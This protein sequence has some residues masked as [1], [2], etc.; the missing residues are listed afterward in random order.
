MGGINVVG[1]EGSV[2]HGAL[3]KSSG[4]VARSRLVRM[5]AQDF[6]LQSWLIDAAYF[7][8]RPFSDL[9]TVPFKVP[10]ATYLDAATVIADH[11]V[12]QAIRKNGAASWICLLKSSV[13]KSDETHY[14]IGL[15]DFNL[16][17]G[18]AGSFSFSQ[19]LRPSADNR[20][21]KF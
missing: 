18:Q 9:E 10:C 2:L 11:L 5:G 15:V 3:A 4:D 8:S 6:E 16:Y 13:H 14:N 20:V 17:G 19:T 21:F 12:N 7:T 1:G